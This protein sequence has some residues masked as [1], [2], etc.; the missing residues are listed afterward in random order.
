VRIVKTAEERRNEILD[1]AEQLF[2]RQGYEGTSTNDIL[3]KVGIARGTLY[4]HFSSKER[5]MDALI[6]RQT[7]R[8]LATARTIAADRNRPVVERIAGAIMALKAGGGERNEMVSHLH[9][10]Q[11][12]LMHLKTQQAVINGLTPILADIVREG[13]EQGLFD[14]P[15]PRESTEMAVVYAITVFDG[16]FAPSSEE[17][18]AA[19][20]RAFLHN[21]ERLLGAE[22]GALTAVM[23]VF[24][25]P[26]ANEGR[27]HP[28][29]QQRT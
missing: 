6:E 10:P 4:H 19:K 16:E 22:R 13:M 11:N 23:Q 17:E 5:I 15:F 18:P 21:T 2:N 27:P 20:I 28:S 25:D 12:A 8:M 9:K 7:E 26:E 3:A 1:A 29:R 14:T 24:G